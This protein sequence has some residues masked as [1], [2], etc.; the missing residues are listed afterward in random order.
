VTQGEWLGTVLL[1]A[2]VWF[3]AILVYK[4]SQGDDE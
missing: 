1:S 2:V 4:W 3:A